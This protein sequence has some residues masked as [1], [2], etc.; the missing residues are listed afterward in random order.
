M[1]TLRISLAVGVS[2]ALALPL[3]A[4]TTT[5]T[6]GATY[7]DKLAKSFNDPEN[8]DNGVPAPGDTVVITCSSAWNNPVYIGI[9]NGATDTIE[10]FDLGAE[11]LIFDISS[12]YTRLHV[13][14]TG[15]GKIVKVGTGM[16]GLDCASSHTGGTEIRAGQL[17]SWNGSIMFGTGPI[18]MTTNYGSK[19]TFGSDTWGAGFA[20]A[21]NF[22][23]SEAYEVMSV[24]QL[25]PFN[26]VLTFE[27][28]ATFA[29][30]YSGL[31]FFNDVEGNGHTL[32]VNG[33]RTEDEWGP[34]H[35]KFEKK[36]DANLVKLGN[37]TLYLNGRTENPDNSLEIRE[38]SC[39]IGVNGFWGGTNIVL[40]GTAVELKVNKSTGLSD[41]SEITIENSARLQIPSGVVLRIRKLTVGGDLIEDGVYDMQGLPS[42]VTG[43]GML[44]VGGRRTVWIGGV[45]G[46]GMGPTDGTPLS[47]YDA[48]NWDNGVPGPGDTLVF[49]NS[50]S[51]NQQVFVGPYGE[52]F[53]IG[54]KGIMI[55]C[56]G[57]NTKT[58]FGLRFT[59]SGAIT[60]IGSG[61]FGCAVSSAHTGGTIVR[62]GFFQPFATL[63]FGTAPIEFRASGTS[64]PKIALDSWGYAISNRVE[65]TGDVASYNLLDGIGQ[66]FIF[67]GEVMAT[68]DFGVKGLYGN[69]TLMEDVSARGHTILANAAPTVTSMK[70]DVIFKKSVDANLLKVGTG[71]L[72]LE[73]VS[74]NLECSLT[75]REGWCEVK[76]GSLWSGTNIVVE[77]TAAGLKLKGQDVLSSEA[78]VRIDTSAGAKIDIASGVKVQ[79]AELF[80]NGS[81]KDPGVYTAARLPN[82]ITG[83]GKLRVGHCGALI[84]I[85]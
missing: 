39:E 9:E 5:W 3:F 13:N 60:K 83:T 19:P 72:L 48:A 49:T 76:N 25:F 21:F 79:I 11:G 58:K 36:V 61:R 4:K 55:E 1:K 67:A 51:W 17:E 8:W 45:T 54:A 14:F 41:R 38:G 64:L 40:N 37:K 66:M 28:D 68:H 63:L 35:I 84:I 42:V 73:G 22:T 27:H 33:N 47:I 10:T 7:K 6:A 43:A 78:T 62:E 50:T 18:E 70:A 32:T 44:V 74:T 56:R 65:L 26:G 59:G 30:T 75:V 71:P 57:D 16:L 53:D 81:A 23:G 69:M 82:V 2:L 52:S 29:C 12:R 85:R 31:V 34:P 20:N 24:G 80:V 46:V 77:S 15:S